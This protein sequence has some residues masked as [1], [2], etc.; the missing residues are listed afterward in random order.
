MSVLSHG[1]VSTRFTS[2]TPH[3]VHSLKAALHRIGTEELA[4]LPLPSTLSPYSRRVL[5][6][7]PELMVVAAR[8]RAGAKCDLHGHSDSTGLYRIISGT[9]EEER[10]IPHDSE[11]EHQVEL[12]AENDE[13]LSPT[14]S[15]HQLRALEESITLHAY[16]PRPVN[17]LSEPTQQDRILLA[18]ARRTSRAFENP[19]RIEF[20]QWGV[21]SSRHDRTVEGLADELA[22][23]WG[24]HEA[25]AYDDGTYRVPFRILEEMRSS[26]IL[27]APVPRYWGG[28]T[29]SLTE[30]ARAVT[31]IATKAPAAALALVMPLANAAVTRISLS[32]VPRD[33]A[34]TLREN[35][36]WMAEQAT[37]GRI[38]AVANSEPGS[39][40][41]LPQTKTVASRDTDGNYYLTGK[42]TFATLGPDADYFLCA[43]RT[44]VDIE[45]PKGIETIIR[46]EGYFVHRD[47]AGVTLNDQW[48]P[49]GM[50]PT[51]SVELDLE[52]APA[53]R[54]YG[55]SGCLEG[56]NARHWSTLLFSA[57]FLGI[58][59]A[60]LSEGVR[61]AGNSP[62]ARAKLAEH[63]LALDAAAGYLEAT[64]EA[65]AWPMPKELLDRVQRVKTFVTQTVVQTATQVAMVSGGRCYSAN[66]PVY[67]LLADS[68]AGPLL[69]PP[70]GNAMETIMDQLV[71]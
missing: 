65:E 54:I 35:Q 26:G 1:D 34:Q 43:A 69:R 60:A 56:V 21:K 51:G 6:D 58:G 14:G 31:K 29:A 18:E 20:P 49:A 25:D 37:R 12:L 30:T 2:G 46:V 36:R 53:E 33:Q 41:H 3:L 47:A 22:P 8:W 28:L 24:K 63:A 19:S 5:V 4:S 11:Y 68:L 23:R 55:Y 50:R 39:G 71:A 10:F 27:A 13:S 44:A 57:V 40:G 32:S 45:S 70:L 66:H 61:N 62:W 17:A 42:K 16:S 59:Q 38:L 15:F 52:Y 67:R 64:C 7:T 9:V 48:D